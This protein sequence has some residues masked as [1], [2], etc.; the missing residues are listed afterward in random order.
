MTDDWSKAHA[1]FRTPL[2]SGCGSPVPVDIRAD[3]YGVSEP[4]RRWA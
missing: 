2:A 1:V 3:L 4:Y